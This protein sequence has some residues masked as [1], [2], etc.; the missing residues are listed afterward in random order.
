M[1]DALL[2]KL[3]GQ[4]SIENRRAE[5]VAFFRVAKDLYGI[6]SV[7]YL[8]ANI[9]LASRQMHYAHCTYSDT[10][11]R[12]CISVRPVCIDLIN[13]LGLTASEPIDWTLTDRP[14]DWGV[15]DD[16]RVLTFSLRPRFGETAIFGI[17]AEMD[18]PEWKERKQ[19]VIRE[20]RILANYFHSHVLRINGHNCNSDILISAR[21]LDCLKWTAAGKT[22]WEASV[23]L[24]ISERT[25]RFHLNAAREKLQCAT[26]TQAVAKA[27]VNQLID[28]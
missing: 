16:R 18:L 6:D 10:G 1:F 24:G 9:S 5:G 15:G 25:V 20:L 17:T 19:S 4:G 11:V 3:L 21:E 22:A 23:I 12:H 14:A 27:I 2:S 28:M 8:G 13:E 26:T 7:E